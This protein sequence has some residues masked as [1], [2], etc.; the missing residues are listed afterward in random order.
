LRKLLPFERPTVGCSGDRARLVHDDTKWPS[1]P[2]GTLL[3]SLRKKLLGLVDLTG[4]NWNHIVPWLKRLDG[5]LTAGIV[6]LA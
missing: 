6:Q 4:V 3:A 1:L 2:L 5:L